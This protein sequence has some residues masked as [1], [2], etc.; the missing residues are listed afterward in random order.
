MDLSKLG[1]KYVFWV[2][3]KEPNADVEGRE[4]GRLFPGGRAKAKNSTRAK[5]GEFLVHGK[6]ESIS[7]L[8]CTSVG[9]GM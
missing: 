4:R 2:S 9:E 3:L 1:G 7:A 5:S 6:A 8:L